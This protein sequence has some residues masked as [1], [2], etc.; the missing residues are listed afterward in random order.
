MKH[1]DKNLKSNK[2]F[3]NEWNNNI[4]LK[5][6]SDFANKIDKLFKFHKKDV[7]NPKRYLNN[8]KWENK[9]N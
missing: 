9:D 2:T 3:L 1:I 8:K 4:K 6:E 7:A 5:L